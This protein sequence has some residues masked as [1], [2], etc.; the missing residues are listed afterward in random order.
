MALLYQTFKPLLFKLDPELAHNLT[1]KALRSGLGPKKSVVEE[2]ALEVRLWDK[3]FPN[4]IGLAA[5]F[6]KNAEVIAPMMHMGFGFVEAGTV[7]PKPQ[8]G[9]PKPRIFRD[10]TYEAVIN[11]MGFPNLGLV[12]FKN[13]LH[14]FFAYRPRPV[15]VLGINIGMNKSQ[16]DPAKDYCLLL[17][18]LGPMA[19]YIT[20]NIS[21][22]NTPGL[23]DLQKRSALLSLLQ[24]VL[25]TR[26]ETCGGSFPPILLKLAPDLNKTQ[27]KELAKT[28]LDAGID[29][30]VLTNTTIGRIKGL[31]H[32][33]TKETGG[34]SGKPLKQ[35]STEIIRNFYEL[36]G[37]T[38][39]II[40]LGGVAD[41]KDAYE[42]IKAGASLV[43]LYTALVFQGP[44]VVNE[45]IKE[46]KELLEQDG[47]S[48]VT[49][50]VGIDTKVGQAGKRK[51][52][53]AKVFK[54]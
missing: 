30:L 44:N 34:L 11:R 40:G 41:G 50:A 52:N 36:T 42:K 47:F 23:R 5:G 10:E 16:K 31:P 13:N 54:A 24:K 4:P 21:S 32:D 9:N 25:K 49:D 12:K 48:S 35:Q 51:N 8:R 43:Q 6:D 22:P 17:K 19:D 37:G 14:K 7:T 18:Q 45:I 2:P 38:I 33:F 3:T 29:G 20:I 26:S 1:I 15:G 46:L 39:P 28:A 53:E 27:Q